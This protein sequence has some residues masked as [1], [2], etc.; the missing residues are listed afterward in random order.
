LFW[1]AFEASFSPENISSGWKR[2]GLLPFD[3]EVVLSQVTRIEEEG[4]NTDSDSV[5]SLALQRPSAR[6]LRRLV[7]NVVD[8]SRASDSSARKLKSTLKSL[9]AEVKLL[10]YENKGLRE[11][12]IH[13]KQRRQRGKALKDYLFDRADPNS[14]QVFSPAKIAQAR[15]KK[16]TIEAKKQEEALKKETDKAERQKKAAA[17][18][19]QALERRMQREEERE[20]KRQAKEARKQEKEANRQIRNALKRASREITQ[21]KQSIPQEASDAVE[22]NERT[23]DEIV[24]AL[25][26]TS[27]MPVPSQLPNQPN[28]E[29]ERQV[30]MNS[31]CIAGSKRPSLVVEGGRELLVSYRDSGRPQRN[32]KRPR[33]L[34]DYDID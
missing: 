15:L 23:Q 28:N 14:A 34:E 7:D 12:I 19:A 29:T 27:E 22:D 13:E 17:Q 18:K 10:R 31:A 21:Q 20:Q 32:S 1:S 30:H 5:D 25:P 11:T 26:F 16:A 8:K 2:T 24:V 3:P 4:P 6:E 33:W 9:Q